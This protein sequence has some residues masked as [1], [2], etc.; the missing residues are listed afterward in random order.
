[1]RLLRAA[2]TRETPWKNGG[3][4]TREI[5]VSP[6]GAGLDDFDWRVSMARVDAG[7]PFS[8]FPGVDRTLTVL[9]GGALTL[10]GEGVSARLSPKSDPFGFSGDVEVAAVIEDG[11]VFD[12]NVM[13]RRA[14]C[15]HSARRLPSV[16]G[17]KCLAD[18]ALLFIV[19]ASGV[20]ARHDTVLLERGEDLPKHDAAALLVEID[21]GLLRDRDACR[22]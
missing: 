10:T 20:L 22:I 3:G 6:E 1:M 21:I 19:E 14:R 8:I 11:P 2:D 13:S 5:A 16:V 9:S 18:V 15:A 7:G 17:V 4:T 12:L